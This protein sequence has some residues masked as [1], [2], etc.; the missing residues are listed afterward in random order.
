MTS[1]MDKVFPFHPLLYMINALRFGFLGVSDVHPG[2]SLAALPAL[3][4]AWFGACF[5][6]PRSGCRLRK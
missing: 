3:T 5:E 1:G 4:A 6:M 2:S